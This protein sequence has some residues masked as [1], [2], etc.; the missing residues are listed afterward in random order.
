LYTLIQE[1]ML[2][3]DEVLGNTLEFN[4]RSW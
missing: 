3:E 2:S 4:L 1:I